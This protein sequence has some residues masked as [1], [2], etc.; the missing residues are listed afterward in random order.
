MTKLI[1]LADIQTLKPISAN[2]NEVKQLNTYILEAQEFDLRPFLG[3]EFYL[4]LIADFEA[5]P[6]LSTYGDL[7]N[8]VDYVYNSDTYRNDG[9]KPMLIYYAYARYLNNAQ[10]IITPNGVVS[11]NFND[12]TPTSDKN[13]AKL[14]NQAFSGGKIYENRVLDYL[15]RNNEDYPLYKCVNPSKRTGGLRISSIRK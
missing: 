4:A 9:I 6:S 1:T 2:V 10:A 14:V 5:S 8:G 13:V 7:F 12:S 11:K 15:V 3:D